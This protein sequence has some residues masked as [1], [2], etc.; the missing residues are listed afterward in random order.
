[1]QQIPLMGDIYSK[2]VTVYACLG[3][4]DAASDQ[5]MNHL[6]GAGFLEFFYESLD[7][8]PYVKEMPAPRVWSAMWALVLARVNPTKHRLPSRVNS[9]KAFISSWSTV[10]SMLCLIRTTLAFLNYQLW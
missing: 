5:A 6:K 1:M 8:E 9:S 10:N 2:A 7:S 3:E 4:G